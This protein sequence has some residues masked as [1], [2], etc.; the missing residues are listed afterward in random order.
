MRSGLSK[1]DRPFY[2]AG[3]EK[4]GPIY[5]CFT[6]KNEARASLSGQAQLCYSAY[7]SLHRQMRK[8][9]FNNSMIK[10]R[11]MTKSVQTITVLAAAL[12]LGATAASALEIK[13]GSDKVQLQLSGDVNR[14]VMY[15]DD[16][17]EDKVFHVDN[18][19]SETK[20]GLSGEV[21][22]TDCLTAGSNLEFKWQDNPSRGVSMAE[23][24]IT[25]KF[26][27]ELVELYLAHSTAGKLSLGKGSAASDESSEI[28]LSGTD[29]IGNAGVAD[30]GGGLA[31]YNA[32]A[33]AYSDF[34]ADAVFHGGISTEGLGKINRALYE[35]PEFGGF[36][37][38]AS[39]GESEMVD[40]SLSY[41]GEFGGNQLEA[42]AAWSN[43]G[44]GW[45][46][47]NGAASLL[48]NSGLNFTVAASVKDVEDMPANGDDPTMLYG[49]IGYQCGK[50]SLGTA[51]ISVDYGI[52]NNAAALDIGQEATAMGVQFV[53]EL[54]G[55]STDLFAGYRVFS[56]EDNT[57]ADY[58][59][60]SVIMAGAKFS[61]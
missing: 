20:I 14:A 58:E 54:A 59:D 13:S 32:A 12:L 41:S 45:T 2:F 37:F 31:F 19:H 16:G 44:E 49:K 60:I 8:A 17:L 56:L 39:A 24:S 40:F 55:Y 61:F 23:E 9:Y 35:T 52:F 48:L 30:L 53:Q 1:F 50:S 57:G 10:K 36:T 4:S 22:A 27:S 43:P 34:T 28:D 46:Q 21:S 18:S 42:K 6:Q 25:G 26:E 3:S 33:G 29:I 15:A 7:G 38:G 51:A 11:M 5:G 47:I